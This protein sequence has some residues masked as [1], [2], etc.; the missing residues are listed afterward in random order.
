M[1]TFNVQVGILKAISHSGEI[2][3]R[4]EYAKKRVAEE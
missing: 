1:E 4:L 3:K 2:E